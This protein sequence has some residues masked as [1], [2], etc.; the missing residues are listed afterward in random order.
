MGDRAIVRFDDADGPVCGVYLHWHGYRAL[1][2]LREA[3]PRMRKGDASYAAARFCGL[4][5]ERIEGGLSLGIMHPDRCTPETAEWQD[6]G[7]YIV[8]CNTGRVKHVHGPGKL[9]RTYR[10]KMGEF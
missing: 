3:A 5:H 10:I 8:D 1:G 6:R 4:A 2:W 9:G 7:M